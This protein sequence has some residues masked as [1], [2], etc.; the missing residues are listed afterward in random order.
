MKISV[1]IPTYNEAKIIQRTLQQFTKVK[2]SHFEVIVTDDGSDDDTVQLAREYADKVVQNPDP[3]FKVIGLNRN[4]GAKAA[5]GDVLWF[6]DADVQL[7]DVEALCNATHKLFSNNDKYV[8]ALPYV[9]VV[10]QQERWI[11]RLAYALANW[12]TWF[13]NRFVKFGGGSGQLQIVRKSSFEK[14]GGYHERLTM[15]EDQD[16]IHKLAGLG[17]IAVWRKH[18]VRTSPRRIQSHGWPITMGQW[19]YFWFNYFVLRRVHNKEWDPRR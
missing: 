6:I 11:D 19:I 12:A 16:L 8:A 2:G 14:V 7:E 1:V 18:I 5:S 9:R 3:L 13:V 4:R 15:G 17:E 10:A